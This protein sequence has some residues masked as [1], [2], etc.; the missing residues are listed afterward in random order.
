MSGPVHNPFSSRKKALAFNIQTAP[1]TP[2]TLTSADCLD[3]ANCSYAPRS[4][5][6]EDPRYTGTVHRPGDILNGASWDV[7]FEWLIHGYSG[8]IPALGAFLP[9]RVLTAVGFTEIRTATAIG[10]EG[11]TSGTTTGATL[12]TTAVGTADLYKGLAINMA[13]VGAAPTGL[14][15]IQA[16]TAGKAATFART[17][18]MAA[19]GNYTI[20]VQ[21]SY[22]LSSTEPEDPASITIWEG[23]NGASGRRMNF[24]DMRPT[25]F[26]IELV[27]SSRDGGD[28][29]CKI[30][31]TFSG[32][33]GSEAA[34]ASPTVSNS[35][36][37]PPFFNGQ[38]DIANV[39]LGGS[40]V[41]IDLGISSGYP[42]NPN[43]SA[44][45]DPGLV[46]STKRTVSYNLNVVRQSVIDFNALAAAQAS[47]PS[48]FIWG[49]ASGNYMG[50]MID[51]QRF[52]YRTNSEGADFLQDSGSAWIDGVDRAIAL[53]FIGY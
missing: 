47:H 23:D 2:I 13:T 6:S 17:R 45:S 5:T 43:Q 33:L 18:T 4:R 41:T 52:D 3:V 9:G 11:Y 10:P 48:Q 14:A 27:T 22:V 49:L 20:P 42:P 25:A 37:I 50:V 31:A 26:T 38:Q 39:Q 40:S 29:Y 28:S 30:T 53:T 36:A 16:Y 21:L 8:A 35:I 46:V 44:G 32:D 34:E 1:G 51:G 24:V 15:M 19:T 12:G 7:S